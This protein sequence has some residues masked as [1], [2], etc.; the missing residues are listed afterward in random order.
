MSVLLDQQITTDYGQFDV[1]SDAEI[2]WSLDDFFTGQLNGWVGAAMPG[3]LHV[4]L[5]DR[6][7]SRV[8]MELHDQVPNLGSWEDIVEVSVVFQ[9]GSV[10][11]WESWA[12][13]S[14]GPLALPPA[15]Y[16]VRVSANGR[17]EARDGRGEPPLDFYLIEFWPATL[18]E[19][20]IIVR[21]TSHDA[22][23]W[24]R[25]FGGQREG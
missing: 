4:G 11:R 7:G 23:Y 18:V 6:T 2:E 20:D 8:R 17:D 22:A 13:E 14:G 3:S 5:A 15:T 12:G 25:A 9:P 10:V 19:D 1:L 24:N 21:T 16:R